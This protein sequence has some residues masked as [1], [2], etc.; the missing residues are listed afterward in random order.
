MV[1]NW[2]TL[3]LDRFG[4]INTHYIIKM[5][6]GLRLK[7]KGGSLQRGALVEIFSHDYFNLKEIIE[8]YLLVI[9]VCFCLKKGQIF[10]AI[11]FY[12]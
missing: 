8:N 4:L 9:L 1:E 11:W 12:G 7:V 5:R 6:N 3:F 2:Y 10:M